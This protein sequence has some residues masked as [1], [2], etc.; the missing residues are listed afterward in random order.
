MASFAIY[1]Q[2]TIPPTLMDRSAT[3]NHLIDVDLNW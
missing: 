3:I 2:D 1:F